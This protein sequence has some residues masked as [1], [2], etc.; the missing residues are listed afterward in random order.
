MGSNYLRGILEYLINMKKLYR[1]GFTLIE[2][3]ITVSVMVLLASLLLSANRSGEDQ[4][5]IAKEKAK[6]VAAIYRARSAA[7]NTAQGDKQACG[8]GLHIVD[9]RH[10]VSWYDTAEVAACGD[11]NIIYDG[12]WENVDEIVALPKALKFGNM[13]NQNFLKDILFVPPDPKVFLNPDP[14]SIVGKQWV[15]EITNG[16]GSTA[17]VAVNRY[18]QI[19]S[20]TG[21]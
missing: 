3:L 11:S 12:P 8:Y 21:Y 4:I 15:L 17:A 20:K 13:G 6:L 16:S 10:Y 7:L 18:G 9:D 5:Q 1:P 2:T 14:A 19:E